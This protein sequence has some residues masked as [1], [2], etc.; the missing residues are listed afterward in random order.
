M[1]TVI[2]VHKND[3]SGGCEFLLLV[4][5]VFAQQ[6]GVLSLI[7]SS[8]ISS[9]YDRTLKLRAFSGRSYQKRNLVAFCA[10]YRRRESTC[11]PIVAISCFQVAV[12]VHQCE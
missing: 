5:D 12:N 3:A 7:S 4:T 1:I 2:D 6:Q 9:L 8:F 10:G 11:L